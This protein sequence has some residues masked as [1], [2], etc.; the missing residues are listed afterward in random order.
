MI[1]TATNQFGKAHNQVVSPRVVSE[2]RAML[3]CATMT[4]AALEDEGG[5][6]TAGNHWEYRLFQVGI[7]GACLLLLQLGIKGMLCAPSVACWQALVRCE[8]GKTRGPVML[9]GQARQHCLS[10]AAAGTRLALC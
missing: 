8:A 7:N 4:G 5:T 3:G 1:S 6:G 2:V 10:H 9:V